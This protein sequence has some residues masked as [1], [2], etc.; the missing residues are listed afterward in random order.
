MFFICSSTSIGLCLYLLILL[1]DEGMHICFPCHVATPKSHRML[2]FTLTHDDVIKWK[3]FYALLAICTGNS[4]V[5]GEFPAQRPVTRSF[6]VF[7]DLCPNKRL[8]KQSWG[9]WFEMPSHPLWRHRNDRRQANL[10]F[11][12]IRAEDGLLKPDNNPTTGMVSVFTW[13]FTWMA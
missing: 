13:N 12:S 7:F 8:S 6:G 3:H 2:L 5:P 4:P 10:Q 11:A 1:Y 9:W